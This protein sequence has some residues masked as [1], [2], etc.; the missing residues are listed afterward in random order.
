MTGI[1]D[2]TR[3]DPAMV[4]NVLAGLEIGEPL[5]SLMSPRIWFDQETDALLVSIRVKSA[6]GGEGIREITFMEP[7]PPVRDEKA[8]A[9]FVRKIFVDMLAHELDESLRFRGE[10]INHPHPESR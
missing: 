7:L 8:V 5:K 6:V 2:G 1:Y 9:H 3:V 10:Y 4:R